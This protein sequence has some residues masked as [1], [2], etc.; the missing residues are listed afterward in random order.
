MHI[1]AQADKEISVK[2]N[3]IYSF[4]EI[5]RKRYVFF[6]FVKV[7]FMLPLVVESI[8]PVRNLFDG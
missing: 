6:N 2:G 1:A 8:S 7:R 3:F 5:D 4:R